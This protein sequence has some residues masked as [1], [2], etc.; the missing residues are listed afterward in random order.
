MKA[1]NVALFFDIGFPVSMGQDPT[2]RCFDSF[3][4]IR[5]RELGGVT[6]WDRLI[7]LGAPLVLSATVSSSIAPRS[8]G[9]SSPAPFPAANPIPA[10]VLDALAGYNPE[11][12]AAIIDIG[13]W[14]GDV[15]R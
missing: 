2:V 10:A 9:L 1:F 6:L 13:K 14:I 3:A 11:R 8:P 7:Q 12:T 15:L 4:T 5:R